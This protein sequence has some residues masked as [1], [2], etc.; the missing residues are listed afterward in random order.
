FNDY[1]SFVRGV[2]TIVGTNSKLFKAFATK[3]K[4]NRVVEIG[5]FY[6]IIFTKGQII[7]LCGLKNFT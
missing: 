5:G 6:L 4:W 3:H 1:V 7:L 2:P